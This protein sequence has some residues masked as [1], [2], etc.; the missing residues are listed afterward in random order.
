MADR[1]S[2]SIT[3]GGVLTPAAYA[4]LAK[5]IAD[6]GLSIEWDGEPFDPAHRTE[7]APLQLFAHEVAGGS[8]DALESWCVLNGIAFARWCCGYGGE[9]RPERVVYTGG[10]APRSF[11]AD[12]NDRIQIDRGDVERLGSV[13][14]LLA[15]FD[16]ADFPIPPL[17]IDAGEE[18]AVR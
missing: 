12:E 1:V 5:I 8:F 2:A 6:E 17:V 15:H 10:G 7:G 11:D 14:A 18:P 9:W 4:D 16:A 3:I 13:A